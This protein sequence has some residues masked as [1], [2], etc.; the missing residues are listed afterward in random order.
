M[1]TEALLRPRGTPA[2]TYVNAQL[3]SAKLPFCAFA[4]SVIAFH[5]REFVWSADGSLGPIWSSPAIGC[6]D[7]VR[8]HNKRAPLAIEQLN[9]PISGHY[10]EYMVFMN[11][12]LLNSFRIRVVLSPTFNLDDGSSSDVPRREFDDI[13]F[14]IGVGRV[15]SIRR[16]I[17]IILTHSFYCEEWAASTKRLMFWIDEKNG[18]LW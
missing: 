11:S 1:S 7:S 8:I 18:H 6:P 16:G 2:A 17:C 14:A 15:A 5:H 12:H 3:C 9:N 13:F 4:I 10:R